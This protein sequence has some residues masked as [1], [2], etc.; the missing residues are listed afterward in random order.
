MRKPARLILKVL[1]T[2]IVLIVLTI[3]GL[4]VYLATRP[5]GKTVKAA[6]II[7]IPAPF[8]IGRPF[9]DYMTINGGRLYA[10]YASQGM[11]GVIDTAT[12]QVLFGVGGLGRVHG[13]A[14]V[15]A[16]QAWL[17]QFERR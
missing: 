6:G 16:S 2:A 1:T 13:V 17:R 5:A 14:I 15:P 11:V 10:G 3:V 4:N 8:K 9:I 7:S 12:N